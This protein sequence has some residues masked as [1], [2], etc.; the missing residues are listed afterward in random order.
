MSRKTTIPI[1]AVIGD[2]GTKYPGIVINNFVFLDTHIKSFE[3]SC[4]DKIPKISLT[5]QSPD[6]YFYTNHFPH[7]GDVLNLYIRGGHEVFKPIRGDFLITNVDSSKQD[8]NI[9]GGKIFVTAEYR[10]PTF[11]GEFCKCIPEKTSSEAILEIATEL[12]L[13]YVTNETALNDKMT[14][15]N[16]FNSY[17]DYLNDIVLHTYKDRVSFY[18]WWIDWYGNINLVNINKPFSVDDMEPPK[19]IQAQSYLQEDNVKNTYIGQKVVPNIL[20]NNPEGRASNF[21]VS[22][23]TILNQSSSLSQKHGYSKDLYFYDKKLKKVVNF[24]ISPTV[25]KDAEKDK[26]TQQGRV[27]ENFYKDEKKSIWLGWQNDNVHEFYKQAEIQNSQNLQEVKKFGINCKLPNIN[28]NFY[29]GQRTQAMLINTQSPP[30]EVSGVILDRAMSGN[31]VI[32][33]I[34]LIYKFGEGWSQELL[35]GR[36]EH[37]L[38][39]ESMADLVKK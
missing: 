36:R 22:A 24:N 25:T 10:I 37:P 4:Y 17:K 2:F 14:W 12:E 34:K 31:F 30:S 16:P 11:N 8:A 28:F 19:E 5:I 18:D 32:M 27:N 1:G 9:S 23:F 6:P 3:M 26:I 29:K 21:F 38:P 35:L 13:G 33:G 7:D 15:I 39:N 20:T